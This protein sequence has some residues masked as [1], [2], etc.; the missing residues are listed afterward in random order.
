[1]NKSATKLQTLL[2]R[3]LLKNKDKI[4]TQRLNQL[5]NLRQ[6]SSNDLFAKR[7][8]ELR[9]AI[10]QQDETTQQSVNQQSS[11]GQKA[12]KNQYKEQYGQT[13]I[14]ASGGT[15]D[16]EEIPQQRYSHYK[17]Y[18]SDIMRSDL[19]YNLDI[20]EILAIL[21]RVRTEQ[22]YGKQS[23]AFY[24]ACLERINN[25]A[26]ERNSN[27]RKPQIL[28][29]LDELNHFRPK[30]EEILDK[31]RKS[32]DLLTKSEIQDDRISTRHKEIISV[33]SESFR[34]VPGDMVNF[35][36]QNLSKGFFRN[37][38]TQF[39]D[40]QESKTKLSIFDVLAS[41]IELYQNLEVRVND[42]LNMQPQQIFPKEALDILVS[43]CIAQ[44]GTN[45][46]I[47][48]LIECMLKR[49]EEYNMTEVELILNY[50]PHVIWKSEVDLS[51]LR[52]RFYYP[53]LMKIRDNVE[54]VDNRQFLGLFQ[55]MT[56]TGDAVFKLDLLN[57][58]LN[59]Y[60]KR[61]QDP[62]NKLSFQDTLIFLELY[63]Q[64]M[65]ANPQIM[66]QVD[67]QQLIQ[68]TNNLV[69]NNEIPS[70]SLHQLSGLF[71]VYG[72]IGGQQSFN[73]TSVDLIEERLSKL[74][75][76]E[77]L[78]QKNLENDNEADVREGLQTMNVKDLEVIEHYYNQDVNLKEVSK[79]QKE[80]LK[81][82]KQ[83]KHWDKPE[84]ER[85]WFHI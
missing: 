51:R 45:T 60:V 39:D 14:K 38:F 80:I 25:L 27:I 62:V 49:Q 74:L 11:S 33:K 4:N 48:K 52:E 58:F 16:E 24:H 50:F 56:L 23:N 83:A 64:F 82:I 69:F 26:T 73:Q 66:E 40:E 71:W 63:V 67:T 54:N 79:R 47:I 76:Q 68:F 2:S 84:N 15:L 28:K 3:V 35:V 36:Y 65:R 19:I 32:Q 7:L 55:G 13:V 5:V 46:L 70:L 42:M 75:R 9:Q 1:M 29:I 34:T 30:D 78:L 20:D 61:T 43:Y 37:L 17:T 85:K 12:E 77:L 18:G 10:K 72:S 22:T 81:L 21:K 41:Y 44:E 8:R 53:I 31:Q 6:F 57:R 59:S